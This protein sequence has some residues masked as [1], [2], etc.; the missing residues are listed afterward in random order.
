MKKLE[1]KLREYMPLSNM[2]KGAY[3]YVYQIRGGGGFTR[4][5]YDLGILPNSELKVCY[6]V[7]RGPMLVEV[8][9]TRLALGRG[10]TKKIIVKKIEKLNDK[11]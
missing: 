2:E 5:L 6:N 4:R 10:I 11:E 9:G 8:K 7:Y 3:C 1:D